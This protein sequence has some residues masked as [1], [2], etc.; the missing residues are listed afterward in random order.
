MKKQEMQNDV[1]K[2]VIKEEDSEE[3]SSTSER[4]KIGV[5][6]KKKLS[7]NSED[8]ILKEKDS[9]SNNKSNQNNDDIN[10]SIVSSG[11]KIIKERNEEEFLKDSENKEIENDKK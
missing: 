11:L 7:W 10:N 1:Y 2:N 4:I 6:L 9:A 5:C 3:K 8:S